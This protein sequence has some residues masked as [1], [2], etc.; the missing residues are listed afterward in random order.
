MSRKDKSSPAHS[1]KHRRGF[2]ATIA[3]VGG[4]AGVTSGVPGET[5][6]KKRVPKYI[7]GGETVQ[8]MKVPKAWLRQERRA[9]RAKDAL[10]DE[11]RSEEGVLRASLVR[12]ESTYGGLNG[13]DIKV[14]VDRRREVPNLPETFRGVTVQSEETTSNSYRKA[15]CYNAGDYSN[16]KGGMLISDDG[17][18][19]SSTG[20]AGYPVKKDGTE[21]M[22]SAQHVFDSC[23]WNVSDTTY[24]KSEK[25]GS[26]EDG[27]VSGDYVVTTA[28]YNGTSLTNEIREPDGTTRTISGAASE[29]EISRRVSD[30]FDGYTTVGATT[31]TTTGGLGEKDFGFTGCNDLRNNA[32]RGSADGAPGDS[33]GPMYSVENGDA[34][35]LGHVS[36]VESKK[37]NSTGCGGVDIIR[38]DKTIGFPAFEVESDGYTVGI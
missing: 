12:S 8:S 35:I 33:G 29:E 17:T 9:G 21:Y 37:K 30:L 38:Y 24:Q 28:G 34:F 14:Y 22:L 27:S 32:I 10:L 18:F 3:G 26:I 23:G 6:R 36:V 5:I 20:T 2:L 11:Y 16:Y 4:L 31:G 7:R 25:L 19:G 1:S 15:G 13:F